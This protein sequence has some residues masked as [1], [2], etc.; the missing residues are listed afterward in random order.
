MRVHMT[1][2]EAECQGNINKRKDG[3]RQKSREPHT[4]SGIPS[5][6]DVCTDR[7]VLSKMFK[8]SFVG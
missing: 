4:W 1:Y 3:L 5:N 7:Q 6:E 2:S 8:G